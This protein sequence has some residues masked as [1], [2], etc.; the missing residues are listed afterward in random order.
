M[1]SGPTL[2]TTARTGFPVAGEPLGEASSETGGQVAGWK[3]S[4]DLRFT[5]AG[6]RTGM[7]CEHFGPLTVQKPFYPEGGPEGGTCHVYLLH[8][9]GGIVGGDGLRINVST[10]PGASALVT[11]PSAGKF[12]RSAGP[13]ATQT[14]RLDVAPDSSLEWLP[15]ETIVYPGARA[16]S[17]T[18]VDLAPGALFLGW[19][20]VCFGLPVSGAP[21]GHGHFEQRF[22]I[23]RDGEPVL[24][25]RGHYA[26]GSALLSELWGLGGHDV[27]GSLFAT[28]KITT[29]GD[30]T[31]EDAGLAQRVRD[32][33]GAMTGDEIFSVTQVDGLLVCRAFGR[34]AW[35]VKG[36]LAQAWAVLREG[37]L[38]RPPCAPRIWNT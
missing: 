21:Y 35:K 28:T 7:A 16:R 36:L 38:G 10:Q 5:C 29:N 34:D 24:L 30:A 20:L 25:E 9:P 18:R 27:M 8:P 4:L 19:E 15:Q 13:L 32:T 37:I 23:F 3:A 26:G 14:Q 22:E 31:N 33:V 17:H 11:T 2:K 12:Y 6:G 1:L